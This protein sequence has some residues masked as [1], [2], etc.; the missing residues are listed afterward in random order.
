MNRFKSLSSRSSDNSDHHEGE[1]SDGEEENNPPPDSALERTGVGVLALSSSYRFHPLA[2]VVHKLEWEEE[3]DEG[4]ADSTGV[5]NE[6]LRV[7]SDHNEDDSRNR[8]DSR[9]RALHRSLSVL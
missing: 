3:K 8:E 5:G 2:S 7:L 9:P 6:C 1:G 4:A